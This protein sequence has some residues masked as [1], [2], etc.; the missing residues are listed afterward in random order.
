GV[1]GDEAAGDGGGEDS[2]AHALEELADGAESGFAGVELG[3]RL[4]DRCDN[5]LLLTKRRQADLHRPHVSVSNGRIARSRLLGAE[6]LHETR[7]TD[8]VV[9]KLREYGSGRTKNREARGC[10]RPVQVR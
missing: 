7:V 5:A 3:E 4:L 10:N 2:V 6:H 1:L 8:R 9:K